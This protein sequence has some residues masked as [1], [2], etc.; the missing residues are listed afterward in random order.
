MYVCSILNHIHS[1]RKNWKSHHMS[2][3][4]FLHKQFNFDFKWTSPFI[5]YVQKAELVSSHEK[6]RAC[7]ISWTLPVISSRNPIPNPAVLKRC[8]P[9]IILFL[10]IS[11][12]LIKLFISVILS[13]ILIIFQ[14]SPPEL[15]NI[16]WIQFLHRRTFFFLYKTHAAMEYK[17]CIYCYIGIIVSLKFFIICSLSTI[18]EHQMHKRS[19]KKVEECNFDLLGKYQ[20]IFFCIIVFVF[21]WIKN[22][23]IGGIIP[24]KPLVIDSRHFSM[25]L[26][27]VLHRIIIVWS[28]GNPIDQSL[29]I[30]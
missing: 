14:F 1:N 4:V 9:H 23:G 18:T 22:K 13:Y 25:L 11:K 7:V 29:G 15:R 2:H 26:A 28:L 3:L 24:Q 19:I 12:S 17:T 8:L 16:I 10:N 6:G 21:F 5:P 30:Q 20:R 27:R